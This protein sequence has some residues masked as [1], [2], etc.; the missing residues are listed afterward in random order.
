MI[1][2]LASPESRE[3][4][5]S[6]ITTIPADLKNKG[7]CLLLANEADPNERN[8]SIGNVPRAN[9]NIIKN[10]NTNDPLLR[11]ESC[12][13]CVKP[14]GKKN[15]AKPRIRGA[16]VLCSI[17]LKNLNS[18]EGNVVLLFA[19]TP[20]KFKPKSNIT[21]EATSPSITVSVKLIPI[22]LPTNPRTP[23]NSAK[24]TSLPA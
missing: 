6:P 20:T 19:K 23:P 24:L 16:K 1:P 12:I 4:S 7:A 3:N 22:A 15:V 14:H 21:N 17:R 10:P 18:S 8:A 2:R 9:A 13:D 11:A 5:P